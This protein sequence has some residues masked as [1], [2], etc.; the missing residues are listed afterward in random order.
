MHQCCGFCDAFVVHVY[1]YARTL[2]CLIDTDSENIYVY[3]YHR[4]CYIFHW[5]DVSNV[6]QM[7]SFDL[8]RVYHVVLLSKMKSVSRVCASVDGLVLVKM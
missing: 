8:L 2:N 3:I 4:L 6:M 5:I 7:S 1:L